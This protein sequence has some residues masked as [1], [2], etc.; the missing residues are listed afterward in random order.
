MR[1]VLGSEGIKR[2]GLGVLALALA[3]VSL[4]V[5][6]GASAEVP[7]I[8]GASLSAGLGLLGAGLLWLRARRRSK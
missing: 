4:A 1:R 3:M 6:V 8:S 5:P 7:E 2:H